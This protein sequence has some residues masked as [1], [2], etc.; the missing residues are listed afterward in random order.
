MSTTTKRLPLARAQQLANAIRDELAPGCAR[1][2][3]AGSI[4][5]RKPEVGDIE[6][7]AIPKRSGGLFD[8]QSALD[9]LLAAL[10][11]TGRFVRIKGGDKYKQYEVVKAG[12]KLDLFLCEP[13]TWG[14][15][16]MLRTG[17]EDFTKRLVLAEQHGGCRPDHI[18]FREGRLWRR[19]ET[20]GHM[21]RD[22]PLDTPEER[23]V[24]EALGMK[25]VEPWDRR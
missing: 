9:P 25:W 6:I 14:W 19:V 10:E 7:V 2:E 1:I 8:D 22:V 24:F 17:P 16:F 20:P 23:D 12:V 3:I 11:G 18:S 21:T 5:R 13:E 4:R 15:I